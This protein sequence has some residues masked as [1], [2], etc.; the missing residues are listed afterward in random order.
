[1]I[2][3]TNIN[4]A[5]EE[6][7]NTI[8]GN[9][10]SFPKTVVGTVNNDN[11]EN[12]IYKLTEYTYKLNGSKI[13]NPSPSELTEFDNDKDN[14]SW[15][16]WV[17]GG[18]MNDTKD[19]IEISNRTV[20][21]ESETDLTLTSDKTEFIENLTSNGYL[22]ASVE[23]IIESG[24]K[25]NQLTIK[26]SK[27]LDGRE[28]FVEA[29]RN[30]P[31]HEA[32]KAYVKTTAVKAAPEIVN[33]YWI[34]QQQNFISS[35][36]F[37]TEISLVIIS[38]GLT[39]SEINITLHDDD[40][41]EGSADD[42]IL[43]PNNDG[44]YKNSMSVSITG[45]ASTIPYQAES[46]ISPAFANAF[47]P[48]IEGSE[49]EAYVKIS[50]ILIPINEVN[51]QYA[52]L[53][54]TSLAVINRLFFASKAT[55]TN[56]NGIITSNYSKL[57]VLYPG[58]TAYLVAEATNMNGSTV[59]FSVKEEM[60]VLVDANIKLPLLEG[61]VQKTDFTAKIVNDYAEVPV[62][63]QELDSIT[64]DEWLDVLMPTNGNL[65]ESILNIRATVGGIDYDSTEEFKII[66]PITRFD[67]FS[68]HE[69]H[70]YL[71]ENA[72]AGKYTYYEADGKNHDLGLVKFINIKN[73]YAARYGSKYNTSRINLLDI[74]TTD[75]YISTNANDFY[76]YSN[77]N[78]DIEIKFNTKRYFMNEDTLACLIG[79]VFNNNLKT[80][81][82]NGFSLAN[83]FPGASTSHKNGYNGDLRYLREDKTGGLLY[84]NLN[85]K[86]VLADIEGWK[87]MDED[88][89]EELIK[90]LHGFGWKSFLS[91]NYGDESER[92]LSK[93][94]PDDNLNHYDHLHLQGFNHKSILIK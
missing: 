74:R 17:D 3:T 40:S 62:K 41:S 82:F 58:Q 37:N 68:N 26:F 22:E 28:V 53:K 14:I 35:S 5:S 73:R 8:R 13:T 60:K 72:I 27:W 92:L 71:I 15:V 57:D 48:G 52:Q 87:G 59:S 21:T 12:A 34:N 33:A 83:G 94:S 93:T 44:T 89:Q 61:T 56:P 29:F 45:R 7:R 38:L 6:V 36:G 77:G 4:I 67:I 30:I 2:L 51:N 69:I 46:S 54:L 23:T 91:Q 50:G 42:L 11:S 19:Y 79:A 81:T 25:I 9:S 76:R 16:F 84:L 86:N 55:F 39:E 32:T 31:D 66:V 85:E 43:W 10:R 88:L 65:E 20:Q 24:S 47:D 63:F 1:M 70:K 75:Q 49:L 78:L 64:Y 80:V 18:L 90:D